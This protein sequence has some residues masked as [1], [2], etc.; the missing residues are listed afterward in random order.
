VFGYWTH[1]SGSRKNRCGAPGWGTRPSVAQIKP[2]A[3]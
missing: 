1:E 2:D 3:V